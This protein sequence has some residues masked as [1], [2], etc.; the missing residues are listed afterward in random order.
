MSGGVAVRGNLLCVTWSAA[1]GHVF[2]FD[3]GARQ[4]V[5]AWSMPAGE[6]GYSDAAGVAMD[7]DWIQGE[8]LGILISIPFTLLVMAMRAFVFYGALQM[9]QG[10]NYGLCMAACIAAC[11][12]CF[13]P[14]CLVGIPFGVWGLVVLN[15]ADVREGFE[16]LA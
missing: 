3:L 15:R 6:R 14:C 13:S 7:D 2:L 9:R 5:S 11:I 1:Q 12:P 4:R 16:G 8:I 10:R